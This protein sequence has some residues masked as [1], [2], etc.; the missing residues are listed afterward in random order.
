MKGKELAITVVN[1]DV[2]LPREAEINV[3][4][5]EA[6]SGRATVLSNT[7]IHAHNTFDAPDTV[8]PRS[9]EWA[10]KGRNVRYTF[11][12]ASVTLL[13]IRLA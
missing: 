11:A 12:P 3:L 4:G 10:A 5:G 2:A 1:P 8:R 6:V 7:D 9:E 13:Q